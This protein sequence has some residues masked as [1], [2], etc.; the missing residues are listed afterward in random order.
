MTKRARLVPGIRYVAKVT[1]AAVLAYALTLWSGSQLALFG[2]LGAAMV[3]GGSF[4]ED[5]RSSLNRVRGTL[6]GTGI[7]ISLAWLLGTSVWSLIL[8]T[9]GMASLAVGLGWGAPAM[10][11]GLAMSLAVLFTHAY[12]AAHYA[13]WRAIDTL[14]G[15]SVGLGISRFV[16]AVR[17]RDEIHAALE[18]LLQATASTLEAVAYD[19]EPDVLVERQVQVLDAIAMVRAAR[20]NDLLDQRVHGGTRS[21]DARVRCGALASVATLAASIKVAD[22]AENAAPTR[23]VQIVRELI[24]P[25]AAAARDVAAAADPAGGFAARCAEARRRAEACELDAEGR[26]VLAGVFADL[27]QVGAALQRLRELGPPTLPR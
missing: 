18:Q 15:V 24:A 3:V 14:I 16:W 10:R 11:I 21:A 19:S 17:G 12:E 25:L 5:L 4:G 26:N 22:L 7:G 27:E 2:A 1:F 23:C 6:A 20:K 9:A 13:F 8:A